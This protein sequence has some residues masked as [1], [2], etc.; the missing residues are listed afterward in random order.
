MPLFTKET[1]AVIYGMQAAAVQTPEPRGT[2]VPSQI[3]RICGARKACMLCVV[4]SFPSILTP[5]LSQK[6]EMS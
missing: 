1:T 5:S 4:P 6:M 2:Q 3:Q